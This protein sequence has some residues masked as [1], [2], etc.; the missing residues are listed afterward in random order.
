MPSLNDSELL[1][2]LDENVA[3]LTGGG[4]NDTRAVLYQLLSVLSVLNGLTPSAGFTDIYESRTAVIVET[5][6]NA[7]SNVSANNCFRFVNSF[8]TAFAVFHLVTLA[9]WLPPIPQFVCRQSRDNRQSR[10]KYRFLGLSQ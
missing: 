8:T 9:R 1:G 7:T 4:S 3:G 10:G 2:H 5:P 6:S